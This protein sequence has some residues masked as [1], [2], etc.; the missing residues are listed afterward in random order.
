M[1][2]DYQWK[3]G[4]KGGTL[5]ALSDYTTFVRVL[6]EAGSARRGRDVDVP[7]LHGQRPVPHKFAA[8]AT[9]ALEMGLRYTNAA[10]AVVHT[11]GAA[12]HAYENLAAVKRLLYGQRDLVT[13]QRVAPDYGTVEVDVQVL[14][15]VTISQT[16]FV[17]MFPL[18]AA[19]PFWR[20]TA[21][22]SDATPA[23]VDVGGNA[24]VDDLW[25]EWVGGTNPTLTH[26]ASG[27]VIGYDGGAIPAGGVRVYVGEG[28]AERISGG[29]DESANITNNRDYWM[30]LEGGA[31][32]LFSETGGST[33]TL[34]W[35][36]RWWV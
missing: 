4:P 23:S 24:P 19:V 3:A 21:Q 33:T 17:F 25:I 15:P 18:T 8:P 20:A 14:Q 26:T 29:A 1:G 32:N 10:G 13:L 27:A 28:R 12:G 22:S 6:A 30:E 7:Y 35:Y 16:R 31:T 2:W 9:I 5:V 36:D 34:K 11:D